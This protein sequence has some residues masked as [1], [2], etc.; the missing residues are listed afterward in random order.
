MDVTIDP[1]LRAVLDAVATNTIIDRAGI[2][3]SRERGGSPIPPLDPPAPQPIDEWIET[4]R[5]RLRLVIVE[6]SDLPSGRPAIL[7]FHGGGYIVGTPE[8]R[9]PVLQHAAAV[10]GATIVAVDYRLAPE[11]PAPAA[12]EDAVA[13][14]RWL[15]ETADRR[16]WDAERIALMGESAGGGLAAALALKLRDLGATIAQL[17]LVYPMLDDR[18]T[19]VGG[20]V[21][22]Y[23]WNAESNAFAWS[24]YLGDGDHAVVAAA[25]PARAT[26]LSGLPPTWIGVGTADL[27]AREDIAFAERLIA[28]QVP[29]ELHVAPGGFHAFDQF[30]PDARASRRFQ[31]SWLSALGTAFTR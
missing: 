13:A 8:L 4:A 7:Q 20:E 16:G 5:G 29:V 6:P 18:T 31:A 10:L 25:V 30:A 24:C 23:L 22:K 1:E 12:L 26:D 28:A 15:V 11:H 21:G 14:Y 27:F 2:R 19:A 9:L 3:R 17:I